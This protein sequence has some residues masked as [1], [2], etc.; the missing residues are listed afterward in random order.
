MKNKTMSQK[1]SE[2]KF[3]VTLDENNLPEKITWEASDANQ[4]SDCKAVM[5]SVWDPK[6]ES[7]LRIDLYTKDFYVEEMKKFFHQS[8]HLMGDTFARAT[9]EEK[10]VAELRDYCDHFAEKMGLIQPK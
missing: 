1:R 9:G 5:V 10:I 3:T 8:L 7:T 6:E 4:Q 2:I